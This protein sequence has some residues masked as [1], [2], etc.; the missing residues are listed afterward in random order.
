MDAGKLSCT[1]VTFGCP[2]DEAIMAMSQAGFSST[3]LWPRD[4]YFSNDG[5]DAVLNVLKKTGMSVSCYQNLRNYEGMP[6]E[7][8]QTKQRIAEQIFM[9]MQLLDTATLV[10]CSNIATDSAGDEDRIISDLRELGDIAARYGRRV[11]WE[12]IC[13]G[14]WVKE[15][16]HAWE[17]IQKVDHPAI[18]I[19]LDSFHIFA[20]GLPLDGI[21]KIDRE[22]IFL[23]EVADIP[24]GNFDFIE[25]SRGYRLFPGEGITPVGD[26]LKEVRKT[27]YDDVLSI[28]VFNSFYRTLAPEVIARRARASL[29]PFL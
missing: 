13:W 9:Q 14:R 15:Y 1:T 22:K 27:G 23:V 8:R 6:E 20:L 17:I 29:E 21:A 5:P 26:F 25:L 3:E 28:E 4:Y 2:V 12:P 24:G 18:G 10:L 11:A 19:V 7:Q 16:W